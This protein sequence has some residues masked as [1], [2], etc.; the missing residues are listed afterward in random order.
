MR[1]RAIDTDGLEGK[2]SV[3]GFTLNARPVPPVNIYP[4]TG[5]SI[6][7][8]TPEFHWA[9]PDGTSSYQLQVFAGQSERTPMID[10]NKL[11][12][13]R[14]T[15]ETGL[16]AGEYQWRVQ[17]NDQQGKPG[18]YGHLQSFR[19]LPEPPAMSDP[20]LDEKSLT[21]QWNADDTSHK[22]QFQ[23][24]H[25]KGFSELLV[26]EKLDTSRYVFSN[27]EPGY[28]YM[29]VCTIDVDGFQGPYS[30]VQRFEVPPADRT[31][32]GVVMIIATILVAL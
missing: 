29:R 23:M 25:D 10:R 3:S 21:L 24:S 6:I 4:A 5:A 7:E 19:I 13:E 22:Y 20:K 14:F 15:A 31:W 12:G 32:L 11:S 9:R 18:P 27:P 2:E 1:V 30:P 8:N 16:P 26:D 28:Y 17:A